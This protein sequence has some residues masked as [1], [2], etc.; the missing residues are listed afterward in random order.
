MGISVKVGAIKLAENFLTSFWIMLTTANLQIFDL[1][2]VM[3]TFLVL[4][5]TNFSVLSKH[6]YLAT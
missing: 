3:V 4:D 6:L 5:F 1:D 2:D